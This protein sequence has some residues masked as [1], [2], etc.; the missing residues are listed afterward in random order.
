[1][2]DQLWMVAAA[3]KAAE[4]AAAAAAAADVAKQQHKQ[5]PPAVSPAANANKD[6][7]ASGSTGGPVTTLAIA[8]AIVPVGATAKGAIEAR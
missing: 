7:S 2:E 6:G 4:V 1:M 5:P 3:A 8:T